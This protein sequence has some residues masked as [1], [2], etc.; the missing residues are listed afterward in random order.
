[1]RSLPIILSIVFIGFGKANA[2]KCAPV[3]LEYDVEHAY[4]IIVG[5]IK[6]EKEQSITCMAQ[7]RGGSREKYNSYKFLVEIDYSY[8]NQLAHEVEIH[9]GKGW[10]DCGA[11]FEPGYNYLIVVFKCDKGYYTQLCSDNAYLPYA[12]CQLNYLNEYFNVNYHP[13]KL[14]FIIFVSLLCLP[15]L[16]SSMWITFNF[17]RYRSQRSKKLLRAI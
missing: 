7:V 11:I 8:K 3:G 17:Y 16:M 4:D 12:S 5:K 1:M 9:G 15:V 14:S 10:G 13:V 6:A 2:C